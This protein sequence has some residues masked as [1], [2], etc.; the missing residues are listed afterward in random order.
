MEGRQEESWPGV[1]AAVVSRLGGANASVALGGVPSV[2]DT[3]G[4]HA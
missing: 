4:G 2:K 1:G 3:G